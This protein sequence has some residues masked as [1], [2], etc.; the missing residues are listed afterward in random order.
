MPDSVALELVDADGRPRTSQRRDAVALVWAVDEYKL[1]EAVDHLR[2]GLWPYWYLFRVGEVR[3][4]PLGASCPLRKD[5]PSV[6]ASARRERWVWV[7]VAPGTDLE[8]VVSCT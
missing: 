8:A 1:A 6:L 7:L 2:R 3:Q 4:L 5:D